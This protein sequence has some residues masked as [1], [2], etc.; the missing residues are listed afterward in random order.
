MLCSSIVGLF[1]FH[2]LTYGTVSFTYGSTG[3]FHLCWLGYPINNRLHDV[4]NRHV[5]FFWW[6]ISVSTLCNQWYYVISIMLE[7]LL[8]NMFACIYWRIDS[9]VRS[10]LLSSLVHGG[11]FP[12]SNKTC[13]AWT[14]REKAHS[15]RP[16]G[17]TPWHSFVLIYTVGP[18]LT[19]KRFKK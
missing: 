8:I 10:Y 4:Y 11:F 16:L 12:F 13:V 14:T 6:L 3:Y 2:L 5:L 7:N 1:H 18:S 19:V 9:S 17:K 15:H